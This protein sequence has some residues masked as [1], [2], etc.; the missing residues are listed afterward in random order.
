MSFLF[1]AWRDRFR[2]KPV[3]ERSS[4]SLL[5]R[6]RSSTTGSMRSCSNATRLST[7]AHYRT[8]TKRQFK[9][10]TELD[11]CMWKCLQKNW[12]ALPSCLQQWCSAA[13]QRLPRGWWSWSH[14][15][16]AHGCTPPL[17]AGATATPCSLAREQ[18]RWKCRGPGSCSVKGRK[19]QEGSVEMDNLAHAQKMLMCRSHGHL[20][21]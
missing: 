7:E 2:R 9:Y 8:K 11:C 19:I 15:A 6:M 17:S 10:W 3:R 1:L 13:L 4:R 20:H 12:W 14:T 18:P 21:F 16:A 5:V